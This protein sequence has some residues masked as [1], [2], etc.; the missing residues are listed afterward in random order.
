M[1]SE[2]KTETTSD[3]ETE[4]SYPN[5]CIHLVDST[6]TETVWDRIRYQISV[7]SKSYAIC[8][9]LAKEVYAALHNLQETVS[10][11]D[12]QKIVYDNRRMIPEP[13]DIYH[14]PIDF[15]VL[16]KNI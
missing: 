2:G 1:D 11:Y 15:I 6:Y 14:I 9:A 5:I 13:P 12:V 8:V 10:S 16:D 4:T 3:P 7:R